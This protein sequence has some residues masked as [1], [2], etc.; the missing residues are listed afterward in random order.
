L[1]ET[2]STGLCATSARGD[3][4]V[5]RT[6]HASTRPRSLA[7]AL[8]AAAAASLAACDAGSPRECSVLCGELD[9]CPDGTSCGTD[10]YCYGPDEV[11][12]S[13]SQGGTPDASVDD[14][15]GAVVD[16]DAGRP[17]AAVD[18]PDGCTGG[19]SFAGQN[20]TVMAIPDADSNG[21]Q[22]VITADSLC[23]QVSTVQVRVDAT[24]TFN[25]DLRVLLTPPAGSTVLVRGESED[26]TDDIHE[27]FD[28]PIAPGGEAAGDWVLTVADVV[29]ND[30]GTLDGW[31][32]GINRPAP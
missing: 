24:H 12:G 20:R 4:P 22:S 25:G 23:A 6:V 14:M 11:P 27:V 15:D 31:T 29:A 3:C 32:L 18:D 1:R 13:C 19:D 8:L 7:A 10:G 26:S 28:V 21:I 16:E 2:G 17:D 9:Q 30:T 5:F